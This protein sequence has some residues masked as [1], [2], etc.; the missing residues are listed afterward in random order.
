MRIRE[1]DDPP[2]DDSSY[3]HSSDEYDS[4]RPD[5]TGRPPNEPGEDP[6]RESGANEDHIQS[7]R[8]AP[9]HF[10]TKLSPEIIPEWNGN[11]KEMSNWIVLINNIAE[12]SNYMRI[13]LGQQVPLRFTDRAL[14]WFNALDKTYHRQITVDWP[15]LRRAIT[16]HFMNRTFMEC[17]KSDAL[18]TKF[19]DRYHPQESPEDYVIRKME[20]LTILSDWTDSELITEIMNSAPD[21]WALYIDTS[22]VNTW[23][24]FLDKVAWHEDKL[25]QYNGNAS[26]DIQQQLDELKTM[27][28]NLETDE[29]SGSEEDS[30]DQGDN[31]ETFA[32]AY[33]KDNQSET[34]GNSAEDNSY[35]PLN[36]FAAFVSAYSPD[37]ADEAQYG[38]EGDIISLEFDMDPEINRPMP[39]HLHLTS[40]SISTTQLSDNLTDNEIGLIRAHRH[41]KTRSNDGIS[42]QHSIISA[43]KQGDVVPG[44]DIQDKC[45]IEKTPVYAKQSNAYLSEPPK[46]APKELQAHSD[47]SV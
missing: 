23:D 11:T 39:K 14:R 3:F 5:P 1:G 33:T 32:D 2:S 12:Y 8:H 28:S 44:G 10:R 40:N 35:K 9:V 7:F 46:E 41:T 30:S 13:Q 4:W 27:L 24:D 17:N 45:Y 15:S 20:A 16:I 25:L 22:V 19:R 42:T 6:D 21:H 37:S 31:E 34:D 18:Y 47:T 38:S 36:S 26:S 29:N 43:S